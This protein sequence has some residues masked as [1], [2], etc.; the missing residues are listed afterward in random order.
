MFDLTGKTALIT[1]GS[2]GLGVVFAHALADAGADIALTARSTDL[3][4]KNAAEIA[5]KGPASAHTGDVTVLADVHRVVDEAI[6]AHGKIDVLVNN[7]GVS[8]T[9]GI[10]SENVDA[11]T[12]RRT[13]EVDL[14]G[15]WSYAQAVGRHMLERRSGSI[16]N[17]SSMRG[18][19]GSEY[20]NPAYH[21]A[22]AAVN[23]LTRLLATEWGDRGVRV[24]SLSPGYFVS[25]MT[26]VIFEDLGL[27][28]WVEGRTP[29]RRLGEDKDLVGP[30]VFLASDEAASVTGANL[31]VDGGYS[32]VMAPTS[33]RCR[34]I[35]G[36]CPRRSVRPIRAR[37]RCPT[38]STS[39]A[40]RASTSRSPIAPR[41]TL[42]RAPT[43]EAVALDRGQGRDRH[44]RGERHGSRARTSSRT[45]A[46]RGRRPRRR[47]CEGRRRR[48]QCCG[49]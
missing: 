31:L 9:R 37:R 38:R 15:V 4:D 8:D 11:D 48:D 19:G 34:G 30:I 26:R 2:Y 17:I 25:E 47:P 12:F 14:F 20:V 16:I 22:K 29:L 23:N 1:G 6:A 18:S 44:W 21:A 36:T 35:C 24:N 46:R 32:A 49:R 41:S 33:S 3:L 43:L 7:A 39:R 5:A 42:D 28:P 13:I 10:A 27:T 45:K 40:C